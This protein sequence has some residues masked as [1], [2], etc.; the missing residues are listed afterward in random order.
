MAV[1]RTKGARRTIA[2]T[3]AYV[4]LLAVAAAILAAD[5]VRGP[6]WLQGQRPA[7]REPGRADPGSVGLR[8]LRQRPVGRERARVLGRAVQQ[9]DRRDRRRSGSRSAARPLA[10]FVFARIRFRGPRGHVHALHVRAAVPDGRRD[11]AAVRPDPPAR[12]AGQPARGRAPAGRLRA[13]AH[14]RHPAAVLPEHPDGARGRGTHRRLRLV[15]LLL[16]GAAAPVAAGARD[17]QRARHRDQ[18]ERV[19]PA[20]GRPELRGP[21]DAAARA[22]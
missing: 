3:A 8:Q 6:R 19:H 20:A 21:V 17:R 14:D 16:A 18:L 11:P 22:S 13:A 15:R 2:G 12:A 4:V 9:R 7:G 5:P 1:A 10:A